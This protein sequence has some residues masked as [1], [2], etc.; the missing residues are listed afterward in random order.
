ML[1]AHTLNTKKNPAERRRRAPTRVID[2]A[3]LLLRG[4]MADERN[5][6]TRRGGGA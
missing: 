2:P 4:E 6:L 3:P 1:D 5:G